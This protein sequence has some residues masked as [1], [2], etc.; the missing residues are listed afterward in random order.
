VRRAARRLERAEPLS[1]VAPATAPLARTR[2]ALAEGRRAT[3]LRRTLSPEPWPGEPRPGWTSRFVRGLVRA[4][5]LAGRQAAQAFPA[6][7]P[8]AEPERP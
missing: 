7:S 4:G 8:S 1:L 3:L 6:A 2:W 5:R